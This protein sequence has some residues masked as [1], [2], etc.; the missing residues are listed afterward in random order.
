MKRIP[1]F[2]VS[3]LCLAVMIPVY[4]AAPFRAQ[5]VVSDFSDQT[6]YE[7]LLAMKSQYPEGM[8]FDNSTPY[9]ADTKPYVWEAARLRCGGCAAF[10]ALLSD[11]VFGKDLP[12][13][14]FDD[15][16]AAR[17]G[18]VLRC[19]GSWGQHTV[20]VLRKLTDS[21]EVAE[22]NY[23]SS[24]HW[25][26]TIPFSELQSTRVYFYTRYPQTGS[27][28]GDING[29]GNISADDAQLVLAAYTKQLSGKGSGLSAAEL[30]RADAD[31]NGRLG[32]ED[33]Q[34][35]L[36]YYTRNVVSKQNIPWNQLLK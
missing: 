1:A 28:R 18:D 5:A 29:S 4:F 21:V 3:L 13:R 2:L 16:H 17:P 14:E 31:Q 10:A 11:A 32:V 34:L 36:V 33:A 23:N 30:S 6:V 15:I 27:L 35:I 25:G 20:I 22:A 26:R 7:A 12:V 9:Q 24:V 19:K 8:R